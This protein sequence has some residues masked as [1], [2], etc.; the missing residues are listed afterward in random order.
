VVIVSFI[1]PLIVLYGG[2][3]SGT[4]LPSILIYDCEKDFDKLMVG[5]MVIMRKKDNN[6]IQFLFIIIYNIIYK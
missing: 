5:I 4:T 2:I 3:S 6:I 1:I